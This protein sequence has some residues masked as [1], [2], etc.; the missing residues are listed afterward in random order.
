[1][2]QNRPRPNLGRY[3]ISR[4]AVLY[5]RGLTTPEVVDYLFKHYGKKE[6]IDNPQALNKYL[7]AGRGFSPNVAKKFEGKTREEILSAFSE[8][9][10]KEKNWR[11]RSSA[12]MKEISPQ[13]SA[14]RLKSRP[15]KVIPSA[16]PNETLEQRKARLRAEASQ[17]M[18]DKYRNDPEFRQRNI[19]NLHR[20]TSSPT[21]KEDMSRRMK[22]KWDDPEYRTKQTQAA[23]AGTRTEQFR[24]RQSEIMI[25]RWR[26]PQYRLR[27]I[28]VVRYAMQKYWSL[29]KNGLLSELANRKHFRTYNFRTESLELGT[30][31]TPA[32]KAIEREQKERVSSAIKSLPLA[33][34]DAIIS[35]F[36]EGESHESAAKKLGMNVAQLNNL[37]NSGYKILANKLL[38]K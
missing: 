23:G 13:L 11:V 8:W 7:F 38:D 28:E 31:E 4:A 26:D 19:D 17:R 14:A 12:K 6:G 21:F 16:F 34:R 20:I 30:I 32:S 5:R 10:R 1:M 25:E 29:V 2:P 3:F 15:K 22:K 18:L 27:Q 24:R 9:S 33:E 35:T 36:F 37:L